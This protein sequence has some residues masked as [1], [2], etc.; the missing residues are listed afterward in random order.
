MDIMMR[1]APVQARNCA[2]RALK[3]CDAALDRVLSRGCAH[4]LRSAF[5]VETY[6]QEVI[7]QVARST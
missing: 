3:L 5:T 7:G 6:S 1:V 4:D 2:N